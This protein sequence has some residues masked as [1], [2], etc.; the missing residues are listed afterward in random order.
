MTDL[1]CA[2]TAVLL[3]AGAGRPAW[4]ARLP[5]AAWFDLPDER[6]AAGFLEETAD[7]FR[8]ETFVLTA[9]AETLTR[10][11]RARGMQG[12]APVAVEID[13]SG[14]HLVDHP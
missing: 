1:Q 9:S 12:P 11:L 8:G 7:R 5:V 3:A 4:L 10:A 13:A 2:A 14:W 6:D